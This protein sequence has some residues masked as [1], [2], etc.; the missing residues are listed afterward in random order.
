MKQPLERFHQHLLHSRCHQRCSRAGF[1]TSLRVG[2]LGA[3]VTGGV[4]AIGG[5]RDEQVGTHGLGGKLI[6]DEELVIRRLSLFED[7]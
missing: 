7:T 5:H 2:D 4:V 3:D 1:I 6:L